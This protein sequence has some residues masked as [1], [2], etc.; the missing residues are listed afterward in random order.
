MVKPGGTGSLRVGISAR[1]APL[2]PSRSFWSLPPSLK[3]WNQV[4]SL[5]IAPYLRVPRPSPRGGASCRTGASAARSVDAADAQSVLADDGE[6]RG[7]AVVPGDRH[8]A[9][10][11]VA[12]RLPQLGSALADV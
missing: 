11:A 1:L 5:V 10:V 8:P 7:R 3:S 6:R 9:L 2:P 12:G 4:V